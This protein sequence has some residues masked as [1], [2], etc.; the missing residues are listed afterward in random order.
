M[1]ITWRYIPDWEKMYMASNTGKIKSVNRWVVYSDGRKYFYKGIE[2]RLIGNVPDG[3]LRVS[4]S[5]GDKAKLFLVHRLV[6]LAF[7]PNP[8]K[9]PFINHKNGIKQDNRP[10]NL[11][12]ATSKEN[13]NHAF[14]NGLMNPVKGVNSKFSKLTEAQV[15][16]IR[17]LANTGLSAKDIAE[18]MGVGY[19]NVYHICNNQTWK[20]LL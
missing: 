4:L 14:A 12:W 8:E 6:A 16:I 5:V 7:I 18:Q 9:K 3:Y 2:R 15:L 20:H 11:E 17:S 19:R 1:I 10:E 13:V